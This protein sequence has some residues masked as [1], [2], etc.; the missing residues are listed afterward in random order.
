MKI[1]ILAI[2]D[3]MPAWVTDGFSDY[4][5]RFTLG[6]S[7]ELCEIPAEKRTKNADVPRII[8]R[9]GE[10]LIAAIKPNHY[11]IA[12]DVKGQAFSTEQLAVEMKNWQ[13]DGRHVD[14]LIGGPDGLSKT[15][16][17]KAHSKWSLSQLTLPHPLVR[18]ILAEQLYRAFS[19]LQNHPYHR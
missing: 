4:V 8:E 11:V 19:I 13:T 9:E 12:L 16:L 3:K 10:K 5:K 2:G 18:I 17:L 7:L 15:C 1:R 14:I 6:C